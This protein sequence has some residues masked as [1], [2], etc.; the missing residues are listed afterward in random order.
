MRPL[1]LSVPN[2]SRKVETHPDS[3]RC[4]KVGRED[5][6]PIGFQPS[7]AYRFPD[8]RRVRRGFGF[9]VRQVLGVALRRRRSGRG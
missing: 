5:T 7:P 9:F 3:G 4:R 2:E 1:P 6:N 8:L